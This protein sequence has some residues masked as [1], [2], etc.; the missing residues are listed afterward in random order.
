MPNKRKAER[1]RSPL[2]IWLQWGP[3]SHERTW[4]EDKINDDDVVYI[5]GGASVS[6][7]ALENLALTARVEK[8]EAENVKIGREYGELRDRYDAAVIELVDARREP[9]EA[10]A[11]IAAAREAWPMVRAH[12][13]FFMVKNELLAIDAALAGGGKGEGDA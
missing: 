3:P 9:D 5:R 11:R 13:N 4:C 8:A 2:H 6:D 7:L 1:D 12:T 10:N